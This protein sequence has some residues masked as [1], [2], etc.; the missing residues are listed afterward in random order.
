M[1][2]YVSVAH[3]VLEQ[4]NFEETQLRQ[5]C[6][7]YKI[8]TKHV[9]IIF[10]EMVSMIQIKPQLNARESVWNCGIEKDT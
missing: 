2:K 9:Y 6:H 7:A 8:K 10:E 5:L 3:A 1:I 4:E